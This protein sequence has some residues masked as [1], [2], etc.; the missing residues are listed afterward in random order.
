MAPRIEDAVPNFPGAR[1]LRQRN[2]ESIRPLGRQFV[3]HRK[4]VPGW[5]TIAPPLA[6]AMRIGWPRFIALSTLAAMLWV[7][8]GL[9]AGML[10]KTQNRTAV[11]SS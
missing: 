4:F 11:D 1:F 6:G 7:G 3:G 2:A 8:A 9:L 10:F 5:A